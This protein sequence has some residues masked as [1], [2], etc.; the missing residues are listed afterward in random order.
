LK[1]RCDEHVSPH[2]VAI[3]RDLALSPGWEISS[4]RDVGDSGYADVHWITKFAEENGD[5]IL[6]ADKDFTT[7]EPQVNAVFDTGLK[8]IQMPGRWGYAKGHLQAAHILLW[9]PCIEKTLSEMS[10][11]ECYRPDW[12]MKQAADMALKKVKIDFQKAQK[13][14]RKSKSD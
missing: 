3:I 5:A 11:R 14:R 2:I 7:L 12:N 4:V 13:K 1:I 8:V 9:W 10:R 6:T